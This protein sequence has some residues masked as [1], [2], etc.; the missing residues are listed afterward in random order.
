MTGGEAVNLFAE[1]LRAED[2]QARDAANMQDRYTFRV[3]AAD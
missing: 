3:A 2:Q 1:A